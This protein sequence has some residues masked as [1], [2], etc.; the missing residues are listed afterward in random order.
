MRRIL[1]SLL[2]AGLLLAGIFGAIQTARGQ[3]ETQEPA[4]EPDGSVL[5]LRQVD[6]E[7]VREAWAPPGAA[8]GETPE[9]INTYTTQTAYCYQPNPAKNECFINWYSNYVDAAP[10]NMR[11]I[12]TT[13]SSKIVA[14]YGGF[15]QSNIYTNYAM[16]G[17][18][19]L[20]ECGALG[21]GGK[22]TLGKGYSWGVTALDATGTWIGHYGTVYCP[23]YMP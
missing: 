6:G 23:A 3:L 9:I 1:I 10:D 16:A 13:I 8:D 20:V 17:Q 7:N 5:I 22:P 19:Y 11:L 14:R 2:A 21:S 18:G 4:T 15:F 12:T